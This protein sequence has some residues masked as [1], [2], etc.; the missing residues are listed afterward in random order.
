MDHMFPIER[1]DPSYSME[2][3]SS[4][5]LADQYCMPLMVSV[6]ITYGPNLITDLEAAGE[7]V[8]VVM[9][10]MPSG[11]HR[12][13]EDEDPA[14]GAYLVEFTEQEYGVLQSQ[15]FIELEKQNY[16]ITAEMP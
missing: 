16:R 3:V 13:I 8:Q 1:D 9:A 14:A 4:R 2:G 15:G 6:V 12:D 11:E 5:E 7:A 10:D